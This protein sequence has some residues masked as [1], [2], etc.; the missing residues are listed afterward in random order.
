[1]RAVTLAVLGALTCA[2]AVQAREVP[3][4]AKQIQTFTLF[5][6]GHQLEQPLVVYRHGQRT[7]VPLQAL[8]AALGLEIQVNPNT[9]SANGWIAGENAN[10]MLDLNQDEARRGFDRFELDPARPW[11]RDSADLYLDAELIQQ[12]LPIS[13][14]F[15][16][17]ASRLSVSS[18]YPL[19]AVQ[20]LEQQQAQMAQLG[21]QHRFHSAGFDPIHP[22][23]Y[24]DLSDPTV[25]AYGNAAIMGKEMLTQDYQFGLLATGDVLGQS[26]EFNYTKLANERSEYRLRFS[27]D[28]NDISDTLPLSLGRY[29]AGD[30]SFLGDNLLSGATE[31]LGFQISNLATPKSNRFGTTALEGNAPPTWQIHLYRN[32]VLLAF[33][34]ADDA[35]RY[36]FLDVPLLNGANV[37]EIHLYG[38]H[39]E[40]QM[41]RETIQAGQHVGKGEVGFNAMYI[42]NT[43][44]VFNSL[45]PEEEEELGARRQ[46]TLRT[47]YG[48]TNAIS[49]GLSYHTQQ[50]AYDDWGRVELEERHYVGANV[51]ADLFGSSWLLEGLRDD[52]GNNAY[53]AGW[54]RRLGDN[55]HLRVDHRYNGNMR[56]DRTDQQEQPLKR[57]T[58]A[59]L[60]GQTWRLGGWQ[61]AFGAA[62]YDPKGRNESTGREESFSVYQNRLSSQ[63]GP[64]NFSHIYRYDTQYDGRLERQSGEV[65]FS[66]SGYDWNLSGNA[67]Y[68]WGKGVEELETRL[69]WRPMYGFYNQ[70]SLWYLDPEERKSRFGIGHEV[71]YR[72]RW[73]TLG[74]QG[75]VDTRGN[76]QVNT[77]A[78]FALNYRDNRD[79][80]PA[81]ALRPQ[82]SDL[83]VRVFLDGNNNGHFDRH[84][85]PLSG[86]AINTAPSWPREVSDDQGEILLRQVPANSL[87]R[88]N[89]DP[90]HLPPGTALRDGPVEVMPLPGQRTEVDL[91][92]VKVTDIDG[93]LVTPYGPVADMPMILADLNH[94]PIHRTR[95]GPEGQFALMG[96][97]PGNYYLVFDERELKARKLKTKVPLYPVNVGGQGEPRR[98]WTIEIDALPGSP[99]RPAA[100][101]V[102]TLPLTPEPIVDQPKMVTPVTHLPKAKPALSGMADSDY[103]LQLAASRQ[104]FNLASLKA[105]FPALSLEQ[106]T[107]MRGG[108]P[109]HLLLSGQYPSERSA[110]F[111]LRDIPK[112]FANDLPLVRRVGDLKREA[113]DVTPT[114]SQP[115]R[116]A[117]STDNADAWLAAQPGSNLTWQLAATKG[118]Q[119][120]EA[121]IRQ[122]QLPQPVVIHQH[123][124]W[125]QILWGS[126]ANR[127][128]AQA[129][130]EALSKAPQNPWLRGIEKLR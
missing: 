81:E 96:V 109:M 106:I 105:Q 19:P 115:I 80:A 54:T 43:R 123:N 55:H 11:G 57:E 60:E 37:F 48:I 127:S 86:L 128:E 77:T 29:Q 113:V 95:T 27:R 103:T 110:R 129:A 82:L 12:L 73:F 91:A 126:F 102:D 75:G 38:N 42:D 14:S 69:R 16:G 50:L 4:A 46:M 71:A 67:N 5:S 58:E 111:G 99:E 62:K 72:Y 98:D 18:P 79:G 89:I 10:F 23:P 84:D 53:M 92:L 17:P 66:T 74:L 25:F 85:Q 45:R 8:S 49:A 64:V 1:M 40:H 36:R 34:E 51:S 78:T 41:R 124:G 52:E 100:Q 21:L 83:V 56:T 122:H 112:E 33:T 28:L 116:A 15:N 97:R 39:G 63:V 119:S 121:F 13:L 108:K 90:R 47:D 70:T 7:L 61:Y 24:E 22:H 94:N 3:L 30:V 20:R 68:Q 88:I 93:T 120:A 65:L 9:A 104:A 76:W 44:F 6:Q 101:M 125:Y 2:Q 32:G 117:V 114:P 35:G 26:Y 31:G 59:W 107:V 130:L 118:R 87:Y